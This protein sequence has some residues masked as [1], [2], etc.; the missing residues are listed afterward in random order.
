MEN[1]ITGQIPVI[2]VAGCQVVF[3]RTGE[4]SSTSVQRASSALVPMATTPLVLA[5]VY[6]S[7]HPILQPT[8]LRFDS[9]H[10]FFKRPPVQLPVVKPVLRLSQ[11]ITEIVDPRK[12]LPDLVH[13][14]PD[15]IVAKADSAVVQERLGLIES[16]PPNSYG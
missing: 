14:A 2:C 15:S 12:L 11:A 1:S 5:P 7:T 10:H 3:R 9:S 6:P 13:G 16:V 4:T 8:R